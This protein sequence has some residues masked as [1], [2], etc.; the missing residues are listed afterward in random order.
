[1]KDIRCL[2]SRCAN[3]Y[4]AAGYVVKYLGRRIDK[5]DKCERNARTCVLT[6][7]GAQVGRQKTKRQTEKRI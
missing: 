3:D 4:R 2:C 1:M 7:R 5:C 6:E